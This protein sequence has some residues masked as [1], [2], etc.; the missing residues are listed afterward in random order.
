MGYT[1]EVDRRMAEN[2]EEP[3]MGTVQF[4]VYSGGVLSVSRIRRLGRR[5][6]APHGQDAMTQHRIQLIDLLLALLLLGLLLIT[7]PGVSLH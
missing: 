6:T 1:P 2:W 5:P 4:P 3:P 7:A